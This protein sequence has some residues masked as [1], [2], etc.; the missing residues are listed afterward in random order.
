MLP[1]SPLG[2]RCSHLGNVH[3]SAVRCLL[4]LPELISSSICTFAA[5]QERLLQ[6]LMR[7]IVRMTAQKQ[8]LEVGVPLYPFSRTSLWRKDDPSAE[9]GGGEEG[10]GVPLP[11]SPPY[12][13]PTPSH[14]HSHTR[15]TSQASG[16]S[17]H[18]EMALSPSSMDHISPSSSFKV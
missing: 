18:D 10:G 17:V 16:W 15:S 5:R 7:E 8:P 9:Q 13:E 1:H 3:L 14:N 11:V 2:L 12:E 4:S 6:G